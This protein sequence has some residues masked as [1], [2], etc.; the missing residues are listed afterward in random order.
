M[1]RTALHRR[2]ARCPS[3][4]AAAEPDAEAGRVLREEDPAVL[5]EHCYKCHSA[6][7]E[8]EK[9]LKGGLKLDT[10]AGLLKGGDTGAGDRA[11]QAGRGHAA[12]VAAVRRRSADAAEGQ[13]AGRG[14]R[15]LREVDRRRRGRPARPATA[16]RPPRHR[17]REGQAVL[18]VPCR[19][20][21]RRFPAAT[22]ARSANPIDALRRTRSGPR[23]G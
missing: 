12:Q 4:A 9:K 18:V 16:R 3:L 15:G 8:K 14:H 20:R 17:H 6:D 22:E 1:L 10:K 5:V 11:R 7:A 21:N 13:A 23:R 19:R 2:S